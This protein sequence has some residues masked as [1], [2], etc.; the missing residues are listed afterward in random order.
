MTGRLA[1][2]AAEVERASRPRGE[3]R[4]RRGA[5]GDEPRGA[6]ERPPQDRG[7]RAA[8]GGARRLTAS[9]RAGRGGATTRRTFWS[10]RSAHKRLDLEMGNGTGGHGGPAPH[11]RLPAGELGSATAS[12]CR[13]RHGARP[14]KGNH[15]AASASRRQ[16]DGLQR[17]HRAAQPEPATPQP[18]QPPPSRS[19]AANRPAPERSWRL[20]PAVDTS[21]S[22]AETR[23]RPAQPAT[24]P[25]ATAHRTASTASITSSSSRPNEGTPPRPTPPR[26]ARAAHRWG[27]RAHRYSGGAEQVL[28]VVAQ[29]TADE[30]R[31]TQMPMGE[32][33]AAAP[34]AGRRSCSS[35]RP[36]RSSCRRSKRACPSTRP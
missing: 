20:T 22:R 18:A 24:P 17:R 5:A 13:T 10:G 26:S 30:L 15:G 28:E 31:R 4:R 36:S 16:E 11:A 23:A 6:Q 14:P 3:R 35:R 8:R 21:S 12:L 27:G 1:E 33:E 32:D 25:A 7:G 2:I 29:Q 19:V 9:E 34:E